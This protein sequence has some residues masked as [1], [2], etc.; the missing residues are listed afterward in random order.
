MQKHMKTSTTSPKSALDIA[1]EL[2]KTLQ[3]ALASEKK[4]RQMEVDLVVSQAKNVEHS[5]EDE[6]KT[7]KADLEKERTELKNVRDGMVPERTG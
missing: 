5:L 2:N 6:I 3:D 1:T 4:A 7:L